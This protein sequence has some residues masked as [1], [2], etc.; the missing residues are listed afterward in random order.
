[1]RVPTTP[2]P[3]FSEPGGEGGLNPPLPE[4]VSRP[5]RSDSLLQPPGE[6]STHRSSHL[7]RFIGYYS[8]GSQN[9]SGNGDEE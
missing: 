1:M 6:F 3:L 5:T 8:Y 2:P 7:Y 4:A 9:N